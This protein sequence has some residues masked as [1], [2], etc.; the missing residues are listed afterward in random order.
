MTHGPNVTKLITRYMARAAIP[1]GGGLADG[2][3]FFQDAEIRK[4][5]IEKSETAVMETIQAIKAA[6]DNPYGDDD[7]RIAGAV[8]A[9]L[10]EREAKR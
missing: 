2:L 9:K 1:S 6:P 5:V 7:E 10:A 8:L 3:R 4:Q